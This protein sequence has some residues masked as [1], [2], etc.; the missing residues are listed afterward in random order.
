MFQAPWQDAGASALNK[1]G[2]PHLEELTISHVLYPHGV[3][4][5]PHLESGA[6]SVLLT[7]DCCCPQSLSPVLLASLWT[8]LIFL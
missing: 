2:E 8:G 5:E 1:I 7:V 6:L 4:L 3:S